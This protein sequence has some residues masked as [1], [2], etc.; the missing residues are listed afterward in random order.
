HLASVFPMATI[1]HVN[2]AHLWREE[3]TDR[4]MPV[5][6]G[7]VQVPDGPGLGNTVNEKKLAEMAQR[8]APTY[9]PFLVQ[10]RYQ[11]GPT[12]YTRHNPDLPGCTD[13]LRFLQ[14]LLGKSIPGPRP[15]YGNMVSTHLIDASNE[16][17]FARLWQATRR[18]PLVVD[19]G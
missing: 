15:G 11:N 6:D 12:I 7:H 4:L 19:A 17:D 16:P 1:D 10:M 3:I 13:N 14:R 18:G 8:P 5:V 2:L 9:Q